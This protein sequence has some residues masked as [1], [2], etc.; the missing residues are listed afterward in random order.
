MY[1]K[2]P[3]PADLNLKFQIPVYRAVWGL[4][5]IFS[6]QFFLGTSASTAPSSRSPYRHPNKKCIGP[7][8]KEDYL[9]FNGQLLNEVRNH[10]ENFIGSWNILHRTSTTHYRRIGAKPQ[11]LGPVHLSGKISPT[12]PCREL[13]QF[14]SSDPTCVRG[15]P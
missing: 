12:Q 3:D 15:L 8:G 2:P 10:R 9:K 1:P 5:N 4:K 14:P 11:A 7:T 6:T 13:S